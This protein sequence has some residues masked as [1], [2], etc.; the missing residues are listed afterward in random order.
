MAS[1]SMQG[2]RLAYVARRLPGT[3]QR[4]AYVPPPTKRQRDADPT[5]DNENKNTMRMV[6]E[7]A[8]WMVYLPSG[9]CYRMSD[10]ELHKRGFDKEPE[11]VGFEQANNQSTNAGKFKLA[12]SEAARQSAYKAM[13]EEVI[14][15][16]QG[17]FG[18]V[19]ALLTDYDPKGKLAQHEK[20]DA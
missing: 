14:K 18:S 5:L 17:R 2:P 19:M 13:E 11:I 3:I 7:D 9:Y 10:A 20:E 1:E 8:G 15:S 4:P 12:R 16:C 6:V